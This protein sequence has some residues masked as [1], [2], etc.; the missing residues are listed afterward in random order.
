M[1]K[2]FIAIIIFALTIVIGSLSIIILNKDVVK[3]TI[4]YIHNNENYVIKIYENK[5]TVNYKETVECIKAPCEPIDKSFKVKFDEDSM[6]KVYDL[7]DEM[8]SDDEKVKDIKSNTIS[9]EQKKILNAV[10]TNDD[11]ELKK[12]E[13][14]TTKPDENPSSN[15]NLIFS[16]RSTR[17][18]CETVILKVYD[19]STYELY[20][21]SD[22]QAKPKTGSYS[23]DVASIIENAS[24]YEDDKKGHF[25]L[26][27]KDGETIKLYS[28]NK[29]LREFLDKIKVNLDT[30]ISIYLNK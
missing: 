3:Y 2:N 21:S 9:K 22:P 14:P 18:N 17:I 27:K 11:S 30:C 5:V 16:I 25:L 6:N 12:G 28:N 4:N 1:K 24:K 20:T 19:D 8:F 13:E 7:V 15:K 10:I 29:E 23:Y 26:T